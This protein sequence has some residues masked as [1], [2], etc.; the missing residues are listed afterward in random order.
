M[1]APALPWR[2]NAHPG[3]I[4]DDRRVADDD[5]GHLLSSAAAG[6]RA[7]WDRLVERFTGLL[8]AIAR[9]HRL[10]Q[11]DAADVVQSTWLRLLDNLGRIQEPDRLGGWLATTARRECLHTLRRSH[12]EPAFPVEEM[13]D[14]VADRT[15]PVDA[16]LLRHE[17]DVALWQLFDELS[18][19]CRRLLRVLI[20]SPPPPYVEV[21]AALDMPIGSIGPTRAR[22]LGR[23]RALVTDAGLVS[24]SDGGGVR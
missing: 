22:C 4:M 11:A 14:P 8:W 7:S 6:D 9:A 12:R 20:A 2:Q 10:S 13:L 15:D 21:A 1:L 17:R 16:D 23:L 19:P 5:L 18:D 3:G 24:D